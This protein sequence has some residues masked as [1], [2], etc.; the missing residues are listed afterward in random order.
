MW[1]GDAA[2]DVVCAVGLSAFCFAAAL[3]AVGLPASLGMP[4]TDAPT[5]EV[6]TGRA[7]G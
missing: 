4:S 6:I 3:S 1:G 2:F 7:E 5:P